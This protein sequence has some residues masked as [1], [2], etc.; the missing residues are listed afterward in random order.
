MRM[1]EHS[2]RKIYNIQSYFYDE[3][4]ANIVRKRQRHAIAKMDLKPGDR[5]LDIGIGTGVSLETYPRDCKITG[6]DLSEG[7]LSH[8]KER[9]SRLG[10]TNVNLAIADAMFMP[11]KEN[12]FDH[13]VISL[14]VTVVSD[15]VK[16][17]NHIKRIG[18]PGC[19]IVIINHFQSGFRLMAWLEKIFNPFF[20]KVGWKSDLNFHELL[21]ETN[22]E[23]DFRYKVKNIDF[24]DIV[25]LRNTKPRLA[26]Y[27][28]ILKNYSMERADD[29]RQVE[30]VISG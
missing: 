21:S 27:H 12:T 7:M 8:A 18:K 25:F 1:E 20:I 4:A 28:D 6:I 14:V 26:T 9:V 15:P 23:V 2:T 5:I 17:L 16:L 30:T 19:R 10:L 22:L 13:I 29:C 3:I 11:F 24:W